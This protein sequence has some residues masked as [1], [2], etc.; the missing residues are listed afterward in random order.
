MS[1]IEFTAGGEVHALQVQHYPDG[2]PRVAHGAD[3][4]AIFAVLL[5]PRS[6]DTFFAALFWIDA[7]R[8]RHGHRHTLLLPFVPGARQDRLTLTG[9]RLF[10]LRSVAQ[11]INDR[12]FDFVHVLDPHSDVAPALIERC[13][14]MSP[15]DILE[16]HRDLPTYQAVIAP[17]GGA[18]K[19]AGAVARMLGVRLLR[20][21]KTRE[22]GTGKISGFGCEPI[23]AG[24]SRALVVD[25]ICDGGGTF[26]GLREV[27]PNAL[28]LDLYVTHGLFSAGT[29]KLLTSFGHIY[30]TDSIIA[31]RPGVTVLPIC[32]TQLREGA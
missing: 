17:D 25:D 11:A 4:S 24:V 27:L 9:D 28:E 13:V 20:A 30:C 2:A 14:V 12:Q 1:E 16:T 8:H 21:W 3:E 31:D 7:L 32:Q 22:V 18:E 15:A 29:E 6:L 10:T 26:L 5:R 19:R 23:P